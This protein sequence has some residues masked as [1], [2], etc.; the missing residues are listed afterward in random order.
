MLNQILKL[1]LWT[2]IP[3]LELRYS[4]PAGIL[5]GTVALPFG[6]TLSGLGMDWKIVFIVCVITNMIL[7]ALIYFGLNVFTKHFI[8]YKFFNRPYQFF[9]RKTQK[10][11]TKYVDKYGLLGVAL[12]ISIPLPGSGSY[13]GALGAHILGLDFKKFIL[14][15]CIGVTIAGILV[16]V[17]TLTGKGIFGLLLG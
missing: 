7:G 9:V 2:L 13:S 5:S 14:A 12:F 1:I 10:R 15:N 4:I 6:M 16:T 17:M 3:F 8:Q 11:I